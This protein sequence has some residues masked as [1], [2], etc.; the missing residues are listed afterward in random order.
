M[1][2]WGCTPEKCH[3]KWQRW[4][5][6]V[7]WALLFSEDWWAELCFISKRFWNRNVL[8]WKWKEYDRKIEEEVNSRLL[9]IL[10]RE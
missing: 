10:E 6:T 2:C 7:C 3:Q 5:P 9:R 1:S 4:W 8:F